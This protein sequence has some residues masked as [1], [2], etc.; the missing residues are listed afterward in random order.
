M[1]FAEYETLLGLSVVPWA[2]PFCGAFDPA[3]LWCKIEALRPKI[4]MKI[5]VTSAKN[6]AILLWR[7][8]LTSLA[9][10][11]YFSGI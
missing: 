10:K 6:A 8:S 7:L 1:L 9:S 3:F 2:G 11:P 5:E 4:T